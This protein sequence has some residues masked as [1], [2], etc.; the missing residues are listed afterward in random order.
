M[1]GL[2]AVSRPIAR[3]SAW[4]HRCSGCNGELRYSI[5]GAATNANG[6]SDMMRSTIQALSA[7]FALALLVS[8]CGCPDNA[9]EKAQMFFDKG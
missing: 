8:G 2:H 6:S 9:Q 1:L 5:D 3:G 7:A 4:R